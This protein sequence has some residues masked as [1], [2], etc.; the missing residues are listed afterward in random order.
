[1][2]HKVGDVVRIKSQKWYSKN[3]GKYSGRIRFKG[4]SFEP[5]MV[6]YLG[7]TAKIVSTINQ[8]AY[9]LNIDRKKWYWTDE[10]FEDTAK[11]KTK[12]KT[13]KE[14]INWEQRRYDMAKEVYLLAIEQWL[15]NYSIPKISQAIQMTDDFISD[16]QK[17]NNT[18]DNKERN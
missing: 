5:E 11:P 15:S 17:N 12:K 9:R 8:R 6:E 16:Y 10:M 2:K 18:K 4:D 13:T 14:T 3:K 7:K 1:M